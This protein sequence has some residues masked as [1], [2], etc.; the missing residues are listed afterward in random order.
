MRATGDWPSGSPDHVQALPLKL[1]KD[2]RA[3]NVAA[4]EAARHQQSSERICVEHANAEHNQRQP[5]QQ[6][7]GR[8]E[9]FAET[10]SAVAA[11]VSDRAAEK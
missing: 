9:C 6:Y 10:Y 3:E 4:W 11:L 5:L 1:R 2:A 7:I 8:W